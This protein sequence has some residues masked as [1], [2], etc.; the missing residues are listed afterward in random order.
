MILSAL[1]SEIFR[2]SLSFIRGFFIFDSLSLI[3]GGQAS[4]FDC[5]DVNEHIF[6]AALRLN[7]TIALLRIE[8]LHGT[9][10]HLSCSIE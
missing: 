9:F 10:R 5:G 8:P 1:N 2:R 7:E 4:P 3:E 6:A